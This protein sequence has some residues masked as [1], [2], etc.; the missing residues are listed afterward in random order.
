MPI[1]KLTEKLLCQ[2]P[3]IVAEGEEV[4]EAAIAKFVLM[5]NGRL[6]DIVMAALRA[7]FR[8]DFDFATVVEEALVDHGGAAG[9]EQVA[10]QA[11]L[12]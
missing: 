3:G 5:F 10:E 1:A 6:T 7:L 9:A 4:A 8:L 2:R 12:T 11:M